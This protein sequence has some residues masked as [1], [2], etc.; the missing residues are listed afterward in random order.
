MQRKHLRIAI[1][2]CLGACCLQR[3]L[4]LDGQF[5]PLDSHTYLFCPSITKSGR[6][7]GVNLAEDLPLASVFS[8][9]FRRWRSAPHCLLRCSSTPHS[10][11]R[12]SP[13]SPASA[14][15][16]ASW[17][18]RRSARPHRRRLRCSRSPTVRGRVKLRTKVPKRRSI[19]WKFS[20]FSS[21][22]K[23]RSPLMGQGLVLHADV[24]VLWLQA[25]TSSFR[26]KAL[27]SS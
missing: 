3:S 4:G 2:P 6:S 9:S 10:G 7:P 23:R 27:A 17:R 13:P 20:A 26:V 25:G 12:R 19:R 8:V 14:A 16:R 21:A 5:F 15:P 18:A 22:S 11:N 1:L 24:D